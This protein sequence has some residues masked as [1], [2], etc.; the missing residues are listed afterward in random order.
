MDQIN[1]ILH[2]LGVLTR[3]QPGMNT[4]N[5][6]F[7]NVFNIPSQKIHWEFLPLRELWVDYDEGPYY[8]RLYPI[9]YQDQAMGTDDPLRLSDNHTWWEESPWLAEWRPGNLNTGAAPDDFA[10]SAAAR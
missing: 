2:H 8:L 7:A 10:K 1:P 5:T 3:W 6:T 4:V 9:A